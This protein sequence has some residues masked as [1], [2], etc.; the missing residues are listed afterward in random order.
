MT[1]CNISVRLILMGLAEGKNFKFRARRS[2]EAG[3]W[4]LFGWFIVGCCV[5]GGMIGLCG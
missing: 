2:G 4:A 1:V 3:L 5:L